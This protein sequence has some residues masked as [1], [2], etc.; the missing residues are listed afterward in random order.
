M[1]EHLPCKQGV[2]GSNPIISTTGKKPEGKDAN[3]GIFAKAIRQR[4]MDYTEI[5]KLAHSSVG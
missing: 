3:G 1:G 4:W 5:T 2:M